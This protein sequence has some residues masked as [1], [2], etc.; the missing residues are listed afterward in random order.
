MSD[1]PTPP[2]AVTDDSVAAEPESRVRARTRRA[3]VEAALEVLSKNISASLGEVAA[4]AG[5][6]RTTLH[7]YFPERSDLISA[8][9]VEALDRVAAAT[10][11]ARP[12]EGPAID[13]L[14]RMVDEHFALGDAFAVV[15][16]EPQLMNEERWQVETE[17]DATLHRLIERGQA[18]GTVDPELDAKWAASLLWATLYT[19]WAHVRECG[20]TPYD[21]LRLSRRALRKA[22]AA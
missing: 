13:A 21:A 10:E 3:I 18:E 15:F 4:A 6:G 11:R 17:A 5:V 19:S 22:L 2:D 20:G 9:G 8:I 14:L 16:H 1:A 12:E 7:R